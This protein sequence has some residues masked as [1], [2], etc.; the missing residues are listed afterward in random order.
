MKKIL[1]IIFTTATA[2]FSF[3]AAN[4]VIL[5]NDFTKI[6]L[7]ADKGFRP[8]S[9]YNKLTNCNIPLI[10]D[11]EKGLWS[12]QLYANG[13]NITIV[14][15]GEPAVE[16]DGSSASFFWQ[17]IYNGNNIFVTANVTLPE[18]SG[19]AEW[20]IS[21]ECSG[22]NI[23][24]V[25]AIDY[26]CLPGIGSI[27][28]D[29]LI[30]PLLFGKILKN[31]ANQEFSPWPT[32]P[33]WWGQQFFAF[34]GS[35]QRQGQSYAATGNRYTDGFFRGADQRETGLYFSADDPKGMRK[36]M[37][38]NGVKGRGYF[39]AGMRHFPQWPDEWREGT[40][41]CTFVIP[42]K[43]LMG[44]FCGGNDTAIDIYKNQSFLC[45][46]HSE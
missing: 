39:T 43:I 18:D 2:I 28:D 36:N 34:S 40:D 4:D 1:S 9:I 11:G 22:N 16:C 38:L 26:P 41:S 3:A 31:P 35:P 13:K 23:P 8:C 6:T 10:D 30:I 21:A 46:L 14:P 44:T 15:E 24:M 32:Y 5:E 27:G 45:H 12:I 17:Q 19:I 37:L 20:S 29:S 25:H 7:A 33:G 42:Y